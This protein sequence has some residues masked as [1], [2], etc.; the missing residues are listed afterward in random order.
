MFFTDI[1]L[2]L[3]HSCCIIII[4]SEVIVLKDRREVPK[5]KE[6]QRMDQLRYIAEHWDEL[7]KSLQCRFDGQVQTVQ[8]FLKMDQA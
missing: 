6:Q 1:L 5:T 4:E 8:D 2:T 7:P 3:K